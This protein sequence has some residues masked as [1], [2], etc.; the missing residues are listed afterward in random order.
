MDEGGA[1]QVGGYNPDGTPRG[2]A[3]PFPGFVGG[4][5]V[6]TSDVTGDG[7]PDTVVG[8]GPGG[9][10]LVKVIDG[11]TGAEVMSLTPFESS[12]TGGVHV[13]A[14][15]V[16]GDTFI[17]IITT[18]DQGGGPRARVIDGKSG[19]TIADFFGI[20][21]PAFRGGARAALADV[22]GDGTPDLLVAAGF[23]GGPRLAGFD[24]KS[25]AS[26]PRKLFADFL[27]FENALR[28]GVFVAAGDVDGDG[29]ADVIAGGGPGG[30]PR[31]YAVSGKG[32]LAS[33]GQTQTPVANFFAGDTTNR[34][35]VRVAARELD[36]D[37]RS[38]LVV[39]AGAG[40][41]SR[42]TGYL[43]TNLSSAGTPP[44]QFAFD[45]FPGFAGGVYVG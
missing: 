25:L 24:G 39:G 15:D 19:G 22:N 29:F 26:G 17:D 9:A 2:G 7:V 4:T 35:G 20:E 37:G 44:E 43:G 13:A 5:R 31:V 1:S 36:G 14:G 27:V 23:G 32:L 33:N 21:D 3:N 38:D 18:P 28:N 34:G 11:K 42:V 41:G 12:F 8:T 40:A 10:P 16:N 30:G 6:A 45:A